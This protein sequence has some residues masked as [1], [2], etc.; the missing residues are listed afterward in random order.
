MVA[1]R[2]EQVASMRRIDVEEDARDDDGF[3]FE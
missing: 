2:M 3:L 1:G